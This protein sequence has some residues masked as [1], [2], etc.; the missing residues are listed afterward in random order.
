YH[1]LERAPTHAY[2]AFHLGLRQGFDAL[3]QL[4][5]H[6]TAEWLPGKAV[7]LSPDCFP[8]LCVG[9]LPVIYPFIV[10]DP[11]EAAPLKRRLGGV[12]LGH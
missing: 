10:D 6:G 8:A 1:D 3:V 4:G 11:G 7:A 5:T 2:L 9:W 12:A